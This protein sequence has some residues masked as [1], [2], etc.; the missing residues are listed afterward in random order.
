M[1]RRLGRNVTLRMA[2]AALILGGVGVGLANEIWLLAAGRYVISDM[3]DSA[4]SWMIFLMSRRKLCTARSVAA[5][6]VAY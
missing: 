2:Q 6:S 1:I 5:H 3:I 4:S